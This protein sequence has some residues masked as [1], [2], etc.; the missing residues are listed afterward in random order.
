MFDV[1]HNIDRYKWLSLY[2]FLLYADCTL[3]TGTYMH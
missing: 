3:Y 2:V 1:S